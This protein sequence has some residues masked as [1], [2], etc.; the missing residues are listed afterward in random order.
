MPTVRLKVAGWL[1]TSLGSAWMNP[2]GVS[3][4]I[5]EGETISEMARQLALENDSFQKIVFDREGLEFGATVLVVLNGI[6]VDPNDR[7][8]TRLKEGDEVMLLPV[9]DGG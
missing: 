8:E 7:L 2:E 5:L 1:L 9:V 4:S 6:F 3:I